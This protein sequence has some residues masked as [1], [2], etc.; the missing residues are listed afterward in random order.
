KV[1]ELSEEVEKALDKIN[2]SEEK[3]QNVSLGPAVF[4][5]PTAILLSIV[6]AGIAVVGKFP[7]IWIFLVFASICFWMSHQFAPK[8]SFTTVAVVLNFV[9][10]NLFLV[11]ISASVLMGSVLQIFLG[12]YI[13]LMLFLWGGS[14]MLKTSFLNFFI[15]SFSFCC[16]ACWCVFMLQPTFECSVTTPMKQNQLF[17]EYLTYNSSDEVRFNLSSEVPWNCFQ[18][19]LEAVGKKIK[20]KQYDSVYGIIAEENTLDTDFVQVNL[21]CSSIRMK[22]VSY[23]ISK[24][25]E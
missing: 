24:Q 23:T 11:S 2:S 18:P 6:S 12:I 1:A 15:V 14:Q 8:G 5:V 20:F 9:L 4:V 19:R 21:V 3:K 17:K 7:F 16:L 22:C 25:L 10:L 13:S